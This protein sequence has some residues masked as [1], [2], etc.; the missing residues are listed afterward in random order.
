MLTKP[1]RS[2][3]NELGKLEEEDKFSKV[4]ETAM[5]ISLNV[6][7]NKH[8]DA[9]EMVKILSLT[10]RGLDPEMMSKV[11]GAKWKET[12]RKLLH[13]SLVQYSDNGGPAKYYTVHPYI[14]TYVENEM[15]AEE[16]AKLHDRIC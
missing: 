4:V 16:K 2:I 12:V 1:C 3:S 8:K 9:S 13:H 5:K 10:P 14:I 7:K 15:P 6:L 11:F